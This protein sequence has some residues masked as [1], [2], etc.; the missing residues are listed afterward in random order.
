MAASKLAAAI[1]SGLSAEELK[2]INT[3]RW[4]DRLVSLWAPVTVLALVFVV[5]LTIVESLVCTYLWL[6]PVMQGLG[7]IC[8]FWWVALLLLRTPLGKKWDLPRAARY[9]A[10]EHLAEADTLVKK[11]KDKLKEK[12][13][14]ELADAARELLRSYGKSTG[15][16]QTASATFAKR[17]DKSL[18]SYRGGAL[19]AGGGFVKALA[20]ALL[21][22]AVL[23][24]PFKIPS[25]SMLPTLELGDQI[26]VNKFLYGVRLPFTNTVPFVLIREPKKGDV[27]VFNNPTDPSVDYVK[28]IV[29]T[30]GDVLTF[31]EDGL[32]VNHALAPRKVENENFATWEHP[33]VTITSLAMFRYW[34]TTWFTDDWHEKRGTLY[35][36]AFDDGRPHLIIDTPAQRTVTLQ[37]QHEKEVTVPP[38]HVFVMG[39]NRNNSAD[40]RLGLGSGSNSTEFVPFGNIKGKATVIW[41]SLSHGGFLS[42]AFGGTGLR[43]D[44]FFKPVTM[45]GDEPPRP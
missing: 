27:I 1:G 14:G 26:F 3:W 12:D 13:L 37:V 33:E 41:F 6:Q 44:R 31:T 17:V 38:G 22:R 42:S 45:C 25:G 24:D 15:E 23:L 10:E 8:F 2:G 16:I 40:S 7:I 18:A 36:E 4:F 32:V 20:I 29:G 28:R 11:A 5:Y 19:D 43:Y 9:L 39:D 34:L 30:P 35:R 21:F